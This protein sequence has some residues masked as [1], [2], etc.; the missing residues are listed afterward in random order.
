MH[1]KYAIVKSMLFVDHLTLDRS[2]VRKTKDGYAVA[3]VPVART[4][5]QDYAGWEVGRPDL[6]KVSVYRP[7]ETVFD[8]AYIASMAHKPITD[9][10]PSVPVTSENWKQYA[11]G[12][13]GDTIR[14]DEA[15]GLVY[16]PMM[17]S[18]QGLIDKLESGQK[19]V[20]CG[21]TCELV[22]GDGATPEGARYHAIQTGAIIN[23]IASVKKGRAGFECR[24]GDSWAEFNES[25]EPS[26]AN[27]KQITFDGVPLEATDAAEAVI[28]KLTDA[29]DSLKKELADAIKETADAQAAHDKALAAKD[30][31]LD[32]LKSKQLSQDAI[33]ALADAKAEIVAQA[34]SI[35]GD[36]DL[37]TKGKSVA[38]IRRATVAAKLGDASVADK[39]DDYVEARF[40]TLKPAETRDAF[41]EAVSD[42]VVSV[43]DAETKRE[44]ARNE[45]LKT[46]TGKAD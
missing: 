18:D 12:Q 33:D 35:L 30:A 9:G 11:H 13:T 42:G 21:Y 17:I 40:D 10:H 44:N 46:L 6:K 36:A 27:V 16:V 25:K 24:I 7:P 26:V 23:H 34:K 29:R 4:G 22:W 19:E 8:D 45:Y 31:E 37:E 20:S 28:N 5:I 3:E 14:K 1:K 2:A 15:N 43:G 39:S 38:E 32:E 41:R